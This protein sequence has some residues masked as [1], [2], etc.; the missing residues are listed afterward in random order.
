MGQAQND[1]VIPGASPASSAMNAVSSA[2]A[3][4]I[5]NVTGFPLSRE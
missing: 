3:L 1:F 2:S 4:M 5:Q